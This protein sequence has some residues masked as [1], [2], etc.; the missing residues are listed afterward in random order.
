[1]IR[2]A[3]NRGSQERGSEAGARGK[4]LAAPE[5]DYLVGRVPPNYVVLIKGDPGTGK[6]SFTLCSVCRNIRAGSKA[7]Y[8]TTNESVDKLKQVA[9]SLGCDMDRRIAEGRVKVVECPTIGDE[10]LIEL[11]TEEIMK[12]VMDGYDIVVIDS[13]T[14]LMRI[15]DTYAKK[16]AWLH[17]VIYKIASMRNVNVFLVCDTL[18]KD[19][20][21][22]ALLEYL[23]DVVIALEYRQESIFPRRLRIT[24][25]RTKPIPS[26]PVYFTLSG[27]GFTA[28]NV[29]NEEEAE[30]V[31]NS[32][33]PLRITEEPV[34]KLF[35]QVVPPGT[36]I[37]IIIKHPASGL[38]LLH[39]YLTFKLGLEALR[40]DGLKLGLI[41][42][43]KA[44]PH[45][46]QEE[47]I[48]MEALR[49][50]FVE[51]PT[52]ITLRQMPCFLMKR[53]C[54]PRELWFL[55]VSGCEKLIET[56]GLK[57][58]NE[59][60]TMYHLLDAKLG[61][62]TLRVFR[63]TPS[64]PTPPSSMMTLS[65]IVIEVTLNEERGC[66]NLRL[67]KG[68][69]ALRPITILDTELSHA[70]AELR[71]EFMRVW[72]AKKASEAGGG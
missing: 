72:E 60:L 30:R 51:L 46:I 17:T 64:T 18:R 36:Q 58:L 56:Y 27:R 23:A 71:K 40:R 42:Y 2:I 47:E 39:R 6:T 28:I 62:T 57:G 12:G 70:V 22:V 41:Y 49:D 66:Y 50:R 3:E 20:A 55:V 34:S 43:G 44:K 33:P 37:S 53:E 16:R 45:A 67:V 19:D 1:L 61:V 25:F 38:G 11:I 26:T 9:R 68:R 4:Y 63:T 59:M 31:R 48:L 13:V 21:D 35:G 29:V 5:L 24:K 7:L 52:D 8:V 65:D 10:Y 69:H 32:K 54:D 15:L 14:P